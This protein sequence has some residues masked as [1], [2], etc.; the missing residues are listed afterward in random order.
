MPDRKFNCA[1]KALHKMLN[2]QEQELLNNIIEISANNEVGLAQKI[3]RVRDLLPIETI[4]IFVES[5]NAV[6]REVNLQAKVRQ[7]TPDQKVQGRI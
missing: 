6:E 2:G 4:T 7:D 5:R 3:T 1:R